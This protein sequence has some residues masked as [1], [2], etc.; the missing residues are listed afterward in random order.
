[1]QSLPVESLHELLD[2]HVDLVQVTEGLQ[3]FRY[4]VRDAFMLDPFTAWAGASTAG[5]RLRIRT[6]STMIRISTQQCQ[7][8]M[9]EPDELPRNFELYVDGALAQRGVAEG[10]S[11]MSPLSGETGQRAASLV[12]AGLRSGNKT[13]ELWFPQ[14]TTQVVA[15]VQI[16]E[17]ARW[18]S[19][20]DTRRRVLFHGSSVTQGMQALGSSGAWPA[21]AA[22]LANVRSINLGWAGSCLLS[23]NVARQISEQVVDGIVLELGINVWDGGLLPCS[24]G[25]VGWHRHSVYS[26]RTLDAFEAASE[27]QASA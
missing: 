10:G 18:Q 23:G 7:A 25:R 6:D 19:W 12:F 4:P 5:V 27:E 21:V 13:V 17:G 3:P 15:S 22:E 2:G 20:P 24:P 9:K 8:F 26:M 1:M 16:D 11:F 14:A